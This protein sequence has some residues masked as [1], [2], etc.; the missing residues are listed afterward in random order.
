MIWRENTDGTYA[1]R[2]P[3]DGTNSI[4][5]WTADELNAVTFTQFNA[6]KR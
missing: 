3:D 4:H 6:I 5:A 1:L 2:D